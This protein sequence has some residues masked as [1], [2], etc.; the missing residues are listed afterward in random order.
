MGSLPGHRQT[1]A[2]RRRPQP[3]ETQLEKIVALALVVLHGGA[4]VMAPIEG[5]YV[6]TTLNGH[7]LPADLRVP[8]TAGDYRLF[9][10][11]QGVLRLSPGGRFT[12]YF[13]YYHQL[14]RRGT[15][16]IVT[17]V[18]SESEAGTYTLKDH[19]LILVPSRKER[20]RSRPTI[21]ATISGEEIRA[22]YLLKNGSASGRVAL[23]LRR[24]ESYW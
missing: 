20:T 2:R 16:P 11:E 3:R 22:S 12:L 24:D 1:D 4:T 9:R 14:V 10:L 23:V 7:A 15:R 6:A 17:P 8:A 5:S 19:Q 21:A 18:L 13:R